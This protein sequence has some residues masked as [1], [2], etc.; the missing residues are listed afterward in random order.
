MSASVRF[1]RFR[2]EAS[3]ATAVVV[4]GSLGLT[5]AALIGVTPAAAATCGTSWTNAAGGAWNV[6]G[7]WSGG[8]PTGSTNACIG[9]GGASVTGT[10]TVTITGNANTASLLLGGSSGTQT[11]SVSTG[12]ANLNIGAASTINANGVLALD[13]TDGSDS[14]LTGSTSLL[15][16]DGIFKILNTSPNANMFVRV[17]VTNDSGGT[18][19]I[20]SPNTF[21]DG[22]NGATTTTNSGT[23]IITAA[24]KLT[25][26]SN[27]FTNLG[28]TLTNNGT[29]TVKNSSTFTQRGGTESGN[30][31]V[32]TLGATLDDDTTASPGAFRVQGQANINGT[33]SNPGVAAGQTVTIAGATASA[34]LST[35][36]TNKGTLVLD[37]TDGT[38]SQLT[39]SPSLLLT[40]DGIF[41]SLNTSPN[42]NMFV[43]VPVTNDSGGT[44]SI[45]SPN[46]FQDGFNGPTTTTNNGTFIV[47][48]AG[49]LTETSGS[50]LFNSGGNAV[51]HIASATVFGSIASVNATVA[52]TVKGLLDS[53]F[54]PPANTEFKVIVDN[55]YAGCFTTVVG[56]F[57]ADCSNIHFQGIG[58]IAG[59]PFTPTTTSLA[60]DTTPSTVGQPVTFTAAVTPTDGGGSVSFFANGS[61]TAIVGCGTVPLTLVSGSTHSATCTTSTL[62][63]GTDAITATYSGD[64]GFDTSNATLAGG[65]VVKPVPLVVTTSSLPSGQIG[66]VYPGATLASTGGT[67]AVTW[68]QTGLPS[69]LSLNATTGAITGTPTGAPRTTSVNVTAT[70]S[71]TPTAQVAHANLSLTINAATL[72]IT[73]F[74]ALPDGAIGVP[75]PPVT[76]TSTG[77]TA[78]IRWAVTG[79]VLPAALSLNP[80]TGVISGTPQPASFGINSFIVTAADSGTPTR[81]VAHL[82]MS[83]LIQSKA[84]QTITFGA[85]G[86][87]TLAQSPFTVSATASSGLAVKFSAT[88]PAVC[89]A[90]GT[91]GATIRLVAVGTCTV[92]ADQAGNGSYKPA[93]TVSR[94]FSVS[95][96]SQ[97]ITFGALGNR[98][99]AQSPFTVSATASSRLAVTFSTTT[100]AVCTAGGAKGATIRLVAVGTCT[101]HADQAGNASNKPAPTVSRSLTVSKA[102]QTITFGALGN[103]TNVASPFAVSATCVVGVA[104]RFL[105][106]REWWSLE[107][108]TERHQTSSGQPNRR[109]CCR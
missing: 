25:V 106:R 84:S 1:T 47:T 70:D 15:T 29:L 2:R 19:S 52:G 100:P 48:S 107:P 71:G 64:T 34:S 73:S 108:D 50:I 57:A 36:I 69:G 90:G 105:D 13:S 16:N 40:N 9:A 58:L 60:S 67:G 102:S 98:T 86:N 5:G 91:N 75:Y 79:G 59:N 68:S 44:V 30:A 18:V 85:L 20:G 10:Y 56:N 54:V 51:F 63:V 87:R 76:L 62:P 21:Q 22:F 81:Q 12:T 65:Q 4:A 61:A 46:T 104:G 101:V 89:T 78:P 103:R 66:T 39:G 99:L 3:L 11:L 32:L 92:H 80:T 33:G 77:G 49:K 6:T 35:N 96:A 45:G 42:A 95:K 28:G 82:T 72:V 8:V 38:D 23:F 43:R 83:I 26:S 97:T 27:A 7:N 41:K 37:S 93:Q 31:V 109:S 94:S 17:P 24:G 14:F 74:A 55:T 53:S 88:T